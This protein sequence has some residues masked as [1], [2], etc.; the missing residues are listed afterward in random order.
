MNISSQS[1]SWQTL[2]VDS[3]LIEREWSN[4]GLCYHVILSA[5]FTDMPVKGTYLIQI[6]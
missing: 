5:A 4:T 6:N 2:Q 1:T 3:E